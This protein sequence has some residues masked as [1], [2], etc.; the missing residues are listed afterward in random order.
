MS[1][2][3]R[4]TRRVQ[5]VDS[6]LCVGLDPHPDDL[7]TPTVE[8]IRE[9]CLRIIEATEGSAAAYKPNIAFFEAYGA[10]GIANLQQ[11]IRSIPNDI[12]IILDAKRGD[13]AST[14]QAYA[15]AAFQQLGADAITINPYLGHD[16]VEPFLEDAEHGVFLLCKTSNL[17][18]GDLQDLAVIRQNNKPEMTSSY[19]LYEEVALLAQEWNIKDNLGLVI[20]ATQPEALR[21][22]RLLV[23]EMWILTPGVGAQGGDLA[24]SM[25]A[26]LRSDG[27]GMLIP[28]SRGISQAA[29]PR[30]AAE[31]IR[32]KINVHRKEF[33]TRP[34]KTPPSTATTKYS[35]D[36]VLLANGLLEAGC[37]K[38]GSYKLKSGIISPIYIDLRL[39][40]SYP[41]LLEQVGRAYI[42]I[43]EKLSFERLAGLPYTALP[44]ATTISLQ[45]NWPLIYP[46]KEAK[47]Y[48]T[49]A[50]IEGIFRNGDR[51]VVID[52]LV[53]S[54]ESKFETIEKL[55]SAG[56]HV[57]DIVVLIDRQSG[58]REV[59][60]N[61]GFRL[62]AVTTLTDL[63]DY[64]EESNK[65]P[66]DKILMVR[67][68][69]KTSV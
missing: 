25:Q 29:D 49:K 39:L 53:T 59:L 26:G 16:A 22:V 61:A 15:R 17:G 45:G 48:G 65:V 69:L 9:F 32:T 13:I 33:Q 36:F 28:I 56:M 42:P 58:A 24:A 18:A 35:D 1:F 44:I 57:E 23:P 52:D 64:Y 14:A 46:R 12:P 7:N 2:F 63:L 10:D 50:E 27:L 55:T 30:I 66:A 21:R 11:I 20:G 47:T 8:A 5:E 51:V 68:F 34:T 60:S 41:K 43:L 19:F 67:E 3:S 62:H 37:I 54:G 38:F 31:E 4:L 40:V 6:L